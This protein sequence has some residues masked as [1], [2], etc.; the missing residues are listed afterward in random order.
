MIF[1]KATLSHHGQARLSERSALASARLLELLNCQRGRKVGCSRRR[2][3]L[4]HRLYWSPADSACFVA[5][6]DVVIGTVL[7]ILSLDMYRERYPDK[8]TDIQVQRVVNEAVLCGD[9]A[10]EL[11]RPTKRNPPIRILAGLVDAPPS[12]L[13][14]WNGLDTPDLDQVGRCREFW[15]WVV[16]R[17]GNRGC[18]IDALEW[19]TAQFP[20]GDPQL[21]EFAC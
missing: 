5:V 3:H 2:S 16:T 10:R 14:Y 12:S 21:V 20:G 18:A 8:L 19:V 1:T 4:V 13:G 9:A 7:T 17:L 15:S 6:Q 11:W